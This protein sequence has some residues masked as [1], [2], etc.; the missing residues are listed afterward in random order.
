MGFQTFFLDAGGG[1]VD[2][3]VFSDAYTATGA[4]DPAEGVEV[5]A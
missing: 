5:T 4:G 3:F 2:V 1:D